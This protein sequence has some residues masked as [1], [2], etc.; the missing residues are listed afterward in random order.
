MKTTLP[1]LSLGAIAVQ[2]DIDEEI[3][4]RYTVKEGR[5][6]AGDRVSVSLRL[7]RFREA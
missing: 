4:G 3:A 6:I 1:A 5:D 7:R 2:L